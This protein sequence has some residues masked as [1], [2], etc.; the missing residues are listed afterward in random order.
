[1]TMKD[2][3]ER[4]GPIIDRANAAIRENPLA[5]GLI[6]AGVAWMLFGGSRG[7]GLAANAVKGAAG[8]A[9][10]AA[11]A[12]GNT[13]AGGLAHAASRATVGL[14]EVAS[15]TAG[16]VASIVPD[17]SLP[18]TDGAFEAVSDSRSAVTKQIN[19]A[20]AAG[21]E[22]GAA[23]QS[24][25]SES[26]ERQPLLLGAIGLAVGAGIAA[27]F[28]TTAIEGEMMGEQGTAAREKLRDLSGGA[29]VLARQVVS[30]VK[31]EADRQGLTPEAATNAVMSVGEKVK[32]VAGAA[33]DSVAQRSAEN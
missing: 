32:S 31:D 12:A 4:A 26:L 14:K 18:D 28:A 24:R 13:A 21:R 19:S 30:D 17:M 5:A 16:L 1:M 11:L 3:L 6:G 22:Y 2:E 25:L 7:M 33:R 23:I 29:K 15:D 27:T 20:A 10:S 9:G 8:K